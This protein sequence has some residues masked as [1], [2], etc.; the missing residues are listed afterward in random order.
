MSE[1]GDMSAAQDADGLE[2]TPEAERR[3]IPREMF[4]VFAGVNVAV[5]NLAVGALGIVL[6]LSL[7]DVLLVYFLGAILGS[8]LVGLCALQGQR[9]GGSVM[10]NARPA[11][12]FEGAR[13]LAVLLFF[14]TAGWFGVNSYFGVTAARS[15][16]EQFGVPGGN[17][18][19]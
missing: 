2:T 19:D 13:L 16:A 8:A 15:I 9:T 10:V 7:T 12:G 18:T 5:T 6:G 11:F 3:G 17:G 1:S 14:T 4:F